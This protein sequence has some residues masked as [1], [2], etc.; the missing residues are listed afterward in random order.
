MEIDINNTLEIKKDT[1]KKFFFICTW[2]CPYV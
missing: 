2:G 1:N